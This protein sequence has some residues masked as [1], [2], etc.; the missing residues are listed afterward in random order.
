MSASLDDNEF[1]MFDAPEDG[2]DEQQLDNGR[3][4]APLLVTPYPLS[5]A[6]LDAKYSSPEYAAFHTS[7]CEMIFEDLE[8]GQTDVVF[9]DAKSKQNVCVTVTEGVSNDD[10]N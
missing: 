2:E 7:E 3:K 8:T 9:Y 4:S 1:D 6:E 10:T 5:S